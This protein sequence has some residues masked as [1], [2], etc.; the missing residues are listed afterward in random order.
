MA[1][2]GFRFQCGV[3]GRRHD[4][5]RNGWHRC[6]VKLHAAIGKILSKE[7]EGHVAL[8]LDV[9]ELERLTLQEGAFS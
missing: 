3:Y 8:G 9:E 5:N 6:F 7:A 1:R 4:P 2:L